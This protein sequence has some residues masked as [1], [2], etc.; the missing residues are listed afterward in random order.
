[1]SIASLN[2][3]IAKVD[4][5]ESADKRNGMVVICHA[6][7]VLRKMIVLLKHTYW[8][9]KTDLAST[10]QFLEYPEKLIF[11][12]GLACQTGPGNL[13]W[14]AHFIVQKSPTY[15]NILDTTVVMGTHGLHWKWQSLTSCQRHPS[16]PIKKYFARS[17]C[18]QPGWSS[19]IWFREN[20]PGWS[21]I[22]DIPN[23]YKG[24]F[25]FLFSKTF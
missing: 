1:M 4:T 11:R 13:I 12:V 8:V 25:F 15:H 9:K 17:V 24:S 22:Y 14:P 20:F 10:E 18:H 7:L 23:I 19:K 16:Q 2:W 5:T 3:L 21:C 6:H